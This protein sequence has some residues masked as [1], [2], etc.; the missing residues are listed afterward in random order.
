MQQITQL[1]RKE[2]EGVYAPSEISF[3]GRIILEEVCGNSFTGITADKINHLSG[4]QERKLKDI[5]Y[6]LSRGEPYQ[7]VIGKSLFH[8]LEFR[9]TPAVLI[10]RPETEEL[11]EWILSGADPQRCSLL[12]IGTGSGCI[13]I[14]LAKRL[15]NAQVDAWDISEDAVK[16]AADNALSNGV[17]VHFTQCDILKAVPAGRRFDLIVSNPPYVTESEM[18]AMEQNVLAYEPHEALFVPDSKPLLY[19]ERIADL[20]MTMLNDRGRLYL[21]INRRSGERIVELLQQ[22]GF[23][24]VELKR[25]LSGN[26]RMISAEKTCLS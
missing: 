15:P 12:D 20:A 19:Y 14:T 16:V 5:L 26:M 6:R 11:V 9:V 3:L 7:Y 8:G 13:A 17:E 18:E 24:S 4:F 2:L 23:V 22:K 21:E 1:I 25:D 10:P